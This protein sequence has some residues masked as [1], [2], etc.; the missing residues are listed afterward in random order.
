ML[1]NIDLRMWWQRK[2]EFGTVTRI[3]DENRKFRTAVQPCFECVRTNPSWAQYEI[4]LLT[5]SE[6]QFSP[7]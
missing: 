6:Y 4:A 1:L 2:A 7:Q 5:T 3:R